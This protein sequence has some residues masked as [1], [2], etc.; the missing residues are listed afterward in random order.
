M[1]IAAGFRRPLAWGIPLVA[2]CM[3]LLLA[4]MALPALHFR[5]PMASNLVLH[6][7]L[8]VVSV[9]VCLMVFSVGWAAHGREEGSA[10]PLVSAVFLAAAVLDLVHLLSYSGM[11]EFVTPSGDGKAIPPFLAA[12]LLVA[13]AMLALAMLPARSARALPSRFELFGISMAIA[14]AVSAATLFDP[15]LRGLFRTAAGLTP[16]KIGLEYAIVGLHLAAVAGFARRLRHA[17]ATPVAHL[18]VANALMALSEFCFTL[19]AATDDQYSNLGHLFKILAYA[20]V[21][22]AMF[23]QTVVR[24]YRLLEDAQAQLRLLN[25]TLEQRVRE[26]TVQLEALNRDLQAFSYSLAHDLR[27]PLAAVQGFAR[28]LSDRSRPQLDERGQHYLQRVEESARRMNEMVSALLELTELSQSPLHREEVDLAQVAAS[29]VED[30][31][32]AAPERAVD[33]RIEGPLPVRADRRLLRMLLANL[34]GNAW[35]FTGRT[36]A[37]ASIEVGA[38]VSAGG[39]RVFHV[40]DN[41]AGFDMDAATRL[42]IPFQRLHSQQQFPGHGIGLANVARVVGLHGGRVWAQ[43]VPGQGATFFFTLGPAAA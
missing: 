39:E 42:F 4:V 29:V 40:R 9:A 18:L 22:N 3:A 11:P 8:E 10:V 16:L 37:P 38:S 19:Y 17:Q 26:R 34:I 28:A 5:L 7:I 27:Q 12:R 36:A 14:L 33:V 32:A 31:R 23:L 24:P 20:L 25:A 41:G 35:K 21:W 13:G 1:G 6:T 43:A 30:L 15:Q 2:A